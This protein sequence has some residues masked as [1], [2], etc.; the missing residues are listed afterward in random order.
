MMP[1]ATFHGRM[2][3]NRLSMKN[4]ILLIFVF[5]LFTV[6]ALLLI[7]E[8]LE[9]TDGKQFQPLS[10]PDLVSVP[11]CT[12]PA[13][14][15]ETQLCDTCGKKVCHEYSNGICRCGKKM[16][17]TTDYFD[18]DLWND[19][20]EKGTIETL[21]YETKDIHGDLH[22]K[23]M[24]VYLPYGY[25]FQTKYNALILLHGT[26]GDEHY[27]FKERGYAYPWGDSPWKVFSNVLDNMI[28]RKIC[29]PVIVVSPTY[30]LNEEAREEGNH[31]EDDIQQMRF[32]V[33]KNILPAVVNRYSTYAAGSDYLSLCKARDHFGFLGASYGGMLCCNAILTYDIDVFSWIAAVSGLYANVPEMNRIWDDLGF[34]NLNINSLYT[35]AGDNDMMREDTEES[36]AALLEFSTK[37]SEQNSVYVLVKDADHE[38]R[39]WD[40][41]VYDCLQYFFGGV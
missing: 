22:V 36:Y 1:T 31:F 21:K 4:R 9:K 23:Q 12:H 20:E 2:Y 27:W 7:P 29:Q 16:T 41:A 37:V 5:L 3:W 40:N 15:R 18:P 17:F 39:V 35:S 13:H 14:N 26:G 19:C 28:S 30:Y 11:E 33:I 24:E 6:S 8:I 34:E 32:E 10:Q 38:E 25:N